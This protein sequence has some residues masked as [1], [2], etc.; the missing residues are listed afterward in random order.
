MCVGVYV[1]VCAC[2]TCG[3]QGLVSLTCMREGD[4][5]GEGEGEEGEEGVDGGRGGGGERREGLLQSPE[6]RSR[7]PPRR[8]C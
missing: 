3:I 4:V 2:A 5:G 1:C 7:P 6:S 8:R